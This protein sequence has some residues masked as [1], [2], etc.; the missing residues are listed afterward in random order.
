MQNLKR[1]VPASFLALGIVF[2]LIGFVQQDFTFSFNS[3]FF[4]LGVIF[5]LSGLVAAALRRKSR[6]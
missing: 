1:N 5:T 6:V 3:G 2:L 4:N